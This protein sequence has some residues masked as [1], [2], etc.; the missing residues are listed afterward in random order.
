MGSEVNLTGGVGSNRQP[1]EP[2]LEFL[3]LLLFCSS[4]THTYMWALKN[5]TY[6]CILLC[7]QK[8]CTV[9]MQTDV[10]LFLFP[11]SL[12]LP[13]PPPPPSLSLLLSHSL[14][15][16]TYFRGHVEWLGR[17]CEVDITVSWSYSPSSL[18]TT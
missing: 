9:S 18:R 17:G 1:A 8:G 15:N 11:A 12:S 10:L 14:S 13:P 6:T 2:C 3:L 16:W 5:V 7:D 4:Y